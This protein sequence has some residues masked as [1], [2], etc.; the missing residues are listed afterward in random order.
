M[1]SKSRFNKISP[2]FKW[3]MAIIGF[4]IIILT[5][6][7]TYYTTFDDYNIFDLSIFLGIGIILMLP[8]CAY[9]IEER[10]KKV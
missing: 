8:L 2:S 7:M 9:I 6:R 3:V 1:K 4:I 5:G 10:K